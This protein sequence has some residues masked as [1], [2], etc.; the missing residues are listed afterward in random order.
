MNWKTLLSNVSRKIYLQKIVKICICVKLI[1]TGSTNP[2]S[3]QIYENT[4]DFVEKWSK[5]IHFAHEKVTFPFVTFPYVILSYFLYFNTDL[6]GNAF[7]LPFKFWYI[8]T[9]DIL[10]TNN[11]VEF[12]PSI[13]EDAIR[14]EN[15]IWLSRGRLWCIASRSLRNHSKYM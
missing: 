7:S 4:N 12:F 14:L 13:F 15:S 10:V 8:N 11:L 5:I 1:F 6:D 3:K 2:I 9:L